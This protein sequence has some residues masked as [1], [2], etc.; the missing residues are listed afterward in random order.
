MK[1]SPW[2]TGIKNL[3]WCLLYRK[4]KQRLLSL[5]LLPSYLQCVSVPRKK[6]TP[7]ACRHGRSTSPMNHQNKIRTR[8]G[9][10]LWET[11]GPSSCLIRRWEERLGPGR[12]Y[13]V[14]LALA[15]KGLL[16]LNAVW[17]ELK[18]DMV[19]Y[20]NMMLGVPRTGK[21]WK[22]KLSTN[23]GVWTWAMD[24]GHTFEGGN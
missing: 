8:H 19:V 14:Q 3:G 23:S 16:R 13:L 22:W 5:S 11:T 4:Q 21:K 20:I 17:R 7:T 1:D 12:T 10:R 24:N 18:C 9:R 6:S 2:Y 15:C